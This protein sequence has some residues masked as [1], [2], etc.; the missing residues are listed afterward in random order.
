MLRLFSMRF[1]T[2][3]Q[4][5]YLPS[6]ILDPVLAFFK[7]PVPCAQEDLSND[8]HVIANWELLQNWAGEG[9]VPSVAD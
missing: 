8:V 6:E 7:V 1:L 9:G 5:N 2:L 4:W 3:L